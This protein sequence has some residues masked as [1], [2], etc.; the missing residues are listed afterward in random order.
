MNGCWFTEE[1]D[2]KTSM[3]GAFHNLYSEE[4]GWRPCIDGLSFMGL[5]SNEVEV[6]ASFFGRR[7]V[8]N[9]L[10]SRQGQ[11]FRFGRLHHGV[12]ALLLGCGEG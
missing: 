3:V 8:C 10:R 6:E 2:L 12:L 5:D 4:G 9:S 11:S 1:N 7:G